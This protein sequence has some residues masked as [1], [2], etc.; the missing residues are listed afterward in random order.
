MS[1]ESLRQVRIKECWSMKTLFPLS[2]AKELQQLERLTIASCGLEEIV[3][4]RMH[5][6]TWLAPKRLRISSFGSIKI[7]GH[8]ES[9]IQHPLFLIEKVIPQLEKVSFTHGDI[10]MI[11]DGQYEVD[12]FCNIKF[13]RISSYFDVSGVFPISLLRR[14]YNLES[15]ELGSCNFKE[16]AYFESHACED[17][18]MIIM[19]PKIKKLKLIAIKNIRHLWKQDSPLDHICATL[20]VWKCNEM[21]ALVTSFKAQSLVCLVTMRIRECEMIRE[22][23]ASN[24]DETSYEIP[25][26]F[27]F[28]EL[29]LKVSILGTSY[30]EPILEDVG[31]VTL[32]PLWN[33]YKKSRLAMHLKFSKFS[34]LIDIWGRSPQEMLDFTTLEF[35]GVCDSNN[36]RYIFYFST[37]FGLR[38]LRKM[39]IKRCGNLEQVIKE[40]GSTTMVE[41]AITDSSKIISIF[42]R[43]Q[44]IIVESCPDMR[45]VYLGNEDKEAIIDDE[46]DSIVMF[47]SDK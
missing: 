24:N 45:S 39:E 33:N 19:I 18:D 21:L 14:F 6:T 28:R 23:V 3:S 8:E 44:S 5:K 46:V 36:L 35:L 10:E 47:F 41:E 16:L 31:L 7:F 13:L 38:Q 27:L 32:M 34:E 22:V 26:K 9:Q 1:F 25:H 20:D 2:I 11:S 15:L 42:P 43:L 30:F 40:E 29:H 4:K 37:T 17:E 12:L